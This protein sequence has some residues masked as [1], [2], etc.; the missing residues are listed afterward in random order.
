[1]DKIKQLLGVGWT[2]LKARQKT[3]LLAGAAIGAFF[4]DWAL[5]IIGFLF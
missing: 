5:G 4:D 1:M 2:W 3:T